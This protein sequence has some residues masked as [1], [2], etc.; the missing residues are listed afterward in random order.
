MSD[1]VAARDPGVQ[2]E[3]TLLAWQRTAFAAGFNS[4][5]LLRAAIDGN[6]RW[7]LVPGALLAVAASATWF[8]ATRA[9]AR[10]GLAPGRGLLLTA[11]RRAGAVA[12]A[13]A[14]TTIVTG[15]A[16]IR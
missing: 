11:R 10:L 7:L 14:V 1:G 16:V 3:R 4:A 12:T 6:G 2:V 8:L 13:V 5:L 15:A 9:Y